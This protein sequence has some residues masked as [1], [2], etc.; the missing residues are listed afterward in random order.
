MDDV[1]KAIHKFN[2]LEENADRL[3]NFSCEISDDE[4]WENVDEILT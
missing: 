1:E 2:E 3:V 4:N